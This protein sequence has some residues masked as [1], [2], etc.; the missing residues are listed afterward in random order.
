MRASLS[1]PAEQPA[2]VKF[3]T[4]TS[5]KKGVRNNYTCKDATA[6]A[7]NHYDG[8]IRFKQVKRVLLVFYF[9]FCE[10]GEKSKKNK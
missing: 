2:G 7:M 6:T 3:C 1:T 5:D 4:V 10:I 9:D 8:R